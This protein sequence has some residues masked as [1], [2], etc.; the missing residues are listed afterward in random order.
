MGQQMAASTERQYGKNLNYNE[1]ITLPATYRVDSSSFRS[2]QTCPECV[3][4]FWMVMR[5]WK[6][7]VTKILEATK[8]YVLI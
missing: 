5:Y 6:V 3:T 2:V 8:K 4:G 1:V 7:F